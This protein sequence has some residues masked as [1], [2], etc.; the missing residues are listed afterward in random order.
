[1]RAARWDLVGSAEVTTDSLEPLRAL[2][3]GRRVGS[4]GRGRPGIASSFPRHAGGRWSSV[5]DLLEDGGGLASDTERATAWAEKLADRH[6]VVTRPTVLAEGIPGGFSGVYPVLQRMEE[7][8][9]IRRGYFIEGAGGAQF[10]LPGAVDRIRALPTGEVTV[11]AAADPANPYGA[12]LPWPEV[13]E[14]RIGRHAGSYVI[15][16]DGR[17]VGFVDG[18]SLRVFDHDPDLRHPIGAA[19]AT[20]AG[21]HRS[22]RVDR[23]D[24]DGIHGSPWAPVLAEMGFAATSRGLAYR[25]G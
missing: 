24:G 11:L 21:R 8:G 16:A 22:F 20:A 7:T 19:L 5:A 4:R 18:R 23:V 10:A 3:A 25:G 9:R 13:P 17:L 12:A 15:M 6:G 14:G 2:L 1:M